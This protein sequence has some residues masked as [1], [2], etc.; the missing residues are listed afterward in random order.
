[1]SWVAATWKQLWWGQ[2]SDRCLL[3]SSHGLDY[4]THSLLSI[5]FLIQMK[6]HPCQQSLP[7]VAAIQVYSSSLLA[8]AHTWLTPWQT[9]GLFVLPSLGEGILTRCCFGDCTVTGIAFR[10]A[11]PCAAPCCGTIHWCSA[12]A[13]KSHYS[14]FLNSLFLCDTL[15]LKGMPRTGVPIVQCCNIRAVIST[16]ET[17]FL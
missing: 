3:I 15:V 14:D 2:R 6:V 17:S 12:M 9:S 11:K 16:S 4:S 1:M 10:E 13:D 8:V 5:Y 7:V